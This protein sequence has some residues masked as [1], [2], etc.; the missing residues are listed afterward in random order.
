MVWL[1]KLSVNPFLS[2]TIYFCQLLIHYQL[3]AYQPHRSGLDYKTLSLAKGILGR[4]KSCSEASIDLNSSGS[5]RTSRFNMTRTTI[6]RS[7]IAASLRP[8][9][10]VRKD[11][12]VIYYKARTRTEPRAQFRGVPPTKTASVAATKSERW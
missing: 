7:S 3:T 6:I 2:R 11:A 9:K 10:S 8:N 5:W 4:R 1:N 12:L